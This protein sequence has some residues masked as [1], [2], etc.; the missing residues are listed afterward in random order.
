MNWFTRQMTGLDD[1]DLKQEVELAKLISPGRKD[2]WII[3]DVIRSKS[4]ARYTKVRG[5]VEYDWGKEGGYIDLSGYYKVLFD[6]VREHLA[7]REID[8]YNLLGEGYNQREVAGIIGVSE[9][10]VSHLFSRIKDK[11]NRLKSRPNAI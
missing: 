5:M 1:I 6:E 10:R 9:G 7:G 3:K 4:K 8:V 11:A 2:E